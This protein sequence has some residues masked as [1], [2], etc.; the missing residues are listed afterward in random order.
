MAPLLIA[1]DCIDKWIDRNRYLIAAATRKRK[2]DIDRVR[3]AAEKAATPE[4]EEEDAEEEEEEVDP[5]ACT[6]KLRLDGKNKVHE[7][8][9]N[10]DEPLSAVIATLPMSVEDGQEVQFICTA[11]RLVVKSTDEHSMTKTLRE[12]GLVPTAAIVIKI[13]REE[14]SELPN[15]GPGKLAERAAAKKKQK[16]GSHTMQSIGVYAKE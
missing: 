15:T 10:A 6:L 1:R 8:V 13:S 9:M 11:K 3:L 12:Y 2:D 5:N 16:K 14:Q 4:E 7:V